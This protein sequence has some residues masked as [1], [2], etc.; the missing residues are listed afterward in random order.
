MKFKN[1][2]MKLNTALKCKRC[3]HFV[4]LPCIADCCGHTLCL[5]CVLDNINC[6]ISAETLELLYHQGWEKELVDRTVLEKFYF[7]MIG[8]RLG[9]QVRI[10]QT[11]AEQCTIPTI[12]SIPN[13]GARNCYFCKARS[14]MLY[15][16]LC[17]HE[18]RGLRMAQRLRETNTKEHQGWSQWSV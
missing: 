7:K 1:R 3:G 17:I 2:G 4:S 5:Q 11:E 12:S 16:N 9:V 14:Y 13:L 8:Q 18:L 10:P 15:P 6:Q